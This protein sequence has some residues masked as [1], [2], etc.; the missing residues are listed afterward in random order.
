[1][2]YTVG[3]SGSLALTYERVDPNYK[4]LGG[5]F[6]TNDFENLT[7]SAQHQGAVNMS[8]TTGVQRDDIAD[9]KRSSTGR[10]VIAGTMAF[11]MGEKMDISTNYSNFQSYSFIQTGFERINRL[12]ALD[13]L[14]TLSYTQLA[15]NASLNVAYKI[16]QTEKKTQALTASINF[17]ES[18]K[19]E[20][21]AVQQNNATRFINGLCNYTVSWTPQSLSVATGV[22]YAIN[23]APNGTTVTI[24]PTL[25]AAK[26]FFNKL[27]MGNAAWAYNQSRSQG[28]QSR[29]TTLSIGAST[30]VKKKHNITF[31]LVGQIQRTLIAKPNI[32]VTA[33]AGYSYSF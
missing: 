3:E 26:P 24:G 4:T 12:T 21:T 8:F 32:N 15:Q 7:I 27:V 31:N 2:N 19:A 10:M 5:L 29:V 33:T 18:A 9:K 14:D 11:K 16:G 30:T 6:F 28:R 17:M 1:M 22:N 25:S 13:N 23:Y 20:N